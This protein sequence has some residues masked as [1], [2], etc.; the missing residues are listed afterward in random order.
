MKHFQ[1]KE[2]RNR[3]K[4]RKKRKDRERE[5]KERKKGRKKERRQSRNGYCPK[6]KMVAIGAIA[7]VQTTRVV[8]NK[9]MFV[10]RKV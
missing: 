7:F 8:G 3:Q 2:E 10:L 5:K 1:M 9:N 6:T 4:E